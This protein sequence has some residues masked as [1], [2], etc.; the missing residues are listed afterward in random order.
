MQYVIHIAMHAYNTNVSYTVLNVYAHPCMW[1]TVP[2][3]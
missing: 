1:Y 2:S 3:K